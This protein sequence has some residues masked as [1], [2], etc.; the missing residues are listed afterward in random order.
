VSCLSVCVV[1]DFS[2]F[3][4]VLCG[5]SVCVCV[6]CGCVRLHVV[7]VVA[8]VVFWFVLLEQILT[9]DFLENRMHRFRFLFVVVEP[10]A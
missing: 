5:R 1:R 7:V 3:V 9:P 10:L 8:V 2:G 6:W 4:C